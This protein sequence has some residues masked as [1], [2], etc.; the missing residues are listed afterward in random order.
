MFWRKFEAC[1]KVLCQR[2]IVYQGGDRENNWNY[3]CFFSVKF[4]N[5]FRLF[6]RLCR[7][8]IKYKI[9]IL[10]VKIKCIYTR[11]KTGQKSIF[12][13]WR[14][15]NQVPGDCYLVQKCGKARWTSRLFPFLS[16][17]HINFIF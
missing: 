15:I 4:D 2:C 7:I 3:A 10:S 17:I 16:L 5:C 9:C 11:C 1:S 6:V 13:R 14:H 8:N 12:Y